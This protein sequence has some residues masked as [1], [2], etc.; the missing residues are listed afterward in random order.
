MM[1]AATHLDP[2]LAGIVGAALLL[3]IAWYWPQLG[4]PG[5][6]TAR[7]RLRRASLVVASIGV[8]SATIGFGL[9]D[10]DQTPIP[11]AIAWGVGGVALL[12]MMIAAIVD[13][14]LSLRLHMNESRAM[15]RGGVDELTKAVDEAR[16][17]RMERRE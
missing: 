15:R 1:I 10:P 13:A 16:H 12:V 5:V 17:R 6:P 11:Y 14:L 4:A 3:A 2:I 9:V 8:C 7:R